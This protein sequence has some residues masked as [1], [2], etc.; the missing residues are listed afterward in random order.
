MKTDYL[1]TAGHRACQRI[2]F[3]TEENQGRLQESLFLCVCLPLGGLC[4]G[5]DL[6]CLQ[7]YWSAMEEV[8]THKREV[9]YVCHTGINTILLSSFF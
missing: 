1:Q 9:L 4:G 6:S 7:I 3:V 5:N 8:V 2:T